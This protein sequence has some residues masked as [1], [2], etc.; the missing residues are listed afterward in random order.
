MVWGERGSGVKV[1]CAYCGAVMVEGPADPVSHGICAFCELKS[2]A[3]LDALADARNWERAQREL[4][5]LFPS[6]V[7]D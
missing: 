4:A 1:V 6:D 3:E 7:R 2:P 5:E